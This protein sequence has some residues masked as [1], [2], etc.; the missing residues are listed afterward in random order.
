MTTEGPIY[1]DYQAT[2]PVDPRVMQQMVPWFDE[3]F[4]NAASIQHSHGQ[5]A[6]MA[7]EAA[8]SKIAALLNADPREIIFTSGATE[9]NNLAIKGALGFQLKHHGR[10]HVIACTTEHKCVLESIA[11]MEAQGATATILPVGEDGLVDLAALEAA[12]TE[13]TVLVSI[14]AANNEIGVLQPIDEIG[15][16][17]RDRGVWFHT[18]AAQAVAKVPVDVEASK[19][20][21]LSISGHKIYGPKGIGILYVRR[22]P[23]VRLEPLFS[24]GGQERGLRSGTLPV[25]LCVGLGATCELAAYDLQDEATR[26]ERLRDRFLAKVTAEFPDVIVN[27]SMERRLP[28]NLNMS[29]PG[30]DGTRLLEALTQISVSSGSACMSEDVEPSYVLRAIGLPDA[31]AA[32]SV[33]LFIGRPTTESEA[34]MAADHLVDVV[35]NLRSGTSIAAE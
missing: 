23:R 19:I 35:R 33:R 34:D 11:A 8:R 20:D 29:F 3:F 26:A 25:P 30:V 18:D 28:G 2:T 14:M 24:G 4:G 31:V 22:R 5:E 13:D 17:C 16:L 9:S 32:A 10:A 21:L 7:V 1:L 12:I 6:E 27:G 15:A